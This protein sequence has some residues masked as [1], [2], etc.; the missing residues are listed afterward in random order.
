MIGL[1]NQ[2]EA[3]TLRLS[4]SHHF[5]A[6]IALISEPGNAESTACTAGSLTTAAATFK[7]SAFA[8]VQRIRSAV[9]LSDAI[10]GQSL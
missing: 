7:A 3:H 5:G 9:A 2:A 4:A 1:R 10:V 6:R 8:I